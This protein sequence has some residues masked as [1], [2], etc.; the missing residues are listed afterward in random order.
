MSIVGIKTIDTF[1]I[2]Q[3]FGGWT[4]MRKTIH[5]ALH[6]TKGYRKIARENALENVPRHTIPVYWRNETIE[7]FEWRDGYASKAKASFSPRSLTT[8]SK[9][10]HIAKFAPPTVPV[11]APRARS[12]GRG[13]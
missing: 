3:T 9:E 5:Y 11:G 6:A 1:T 8:S 7:R 13:R 12:A 4:R 10:M 2:S